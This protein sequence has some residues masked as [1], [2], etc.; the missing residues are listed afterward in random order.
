VWQLLSDAQHPEHEVPSQTQLPPE[1]CSPDRHVAVDPHAH[2]PPAQV[3][4]VWVQSA[5]EAPDPPQVV[6]PLVW[7]LLSDAQHPEHEVPS[8]TQLPPEQCSP[9]GHVAVAPHPHDPPEQVLPVWVQ[10]AQE[11]PD[12]PQVVLPLVWQVPSEA[13]HP[14][15][16]LESHA[17][18]PETQCW[19]DAH[20]PPEPH[21]HAEEEQVIP[22]CVQSV[23]A[24]PAP[25][26]VWSLSV[27]H[28]PDAEQQPA[29]D[30][31]LHVHALLTHACPAGHFAFEPHLHTPV[32]EQLSAL[33]G[34]HDVHDPPPVPQLP[35]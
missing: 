12:P 17:Q 10:S 32:S 16:E 26:H 23:H 2:A 24:F 21:E 7:Q 29:H 14:E 9:D 4:P 25:P 15:H 28:C 1:Q 33:E 20:G 27:W 31:E 5:Q 18:L 13:Q 8:Q 34:S 35:K 19:P 3:R 30:V 22:I 11:A 6:L